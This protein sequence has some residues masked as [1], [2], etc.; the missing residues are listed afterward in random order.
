MESSRRR[1]GLVLRRSCWTQNHTWPR[2]WPK[3]VPMAIVLEG[4][5]GA[6]V[7]GVV[8]ESWEWGFVGESIMSSRR[9][10]LRR[11]LVVGGEGVGAAG[12]KQGRIYR[13][14]MSILVM[15]KFWE[16]GSEE[17]ERVLREEC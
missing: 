7:V 13:R 6:A 15:V 11:F 5:G 16:T 3:M 4:R 14:R 12:E 2:R 1:E 9:E 17:K 10:V 8:G